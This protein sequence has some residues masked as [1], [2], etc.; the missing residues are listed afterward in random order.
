MLMKKFSDN[1]GQAMVESLI[2]LTLLAGLLLLLTDTVFPLHEHQLKRIETGR[3]AVWNWQLNSTVEVTENYAFAKRAEVVL[4]PLKGLTGLALEQDNL[5]VIASAPD[6]AAMARLT[7]TW[8][9]MSAEQLDSRPAR[10]TPLARLQELGLGKI[11]NFI[12]WLHFTEE[13]S[14]ESLRFGYIANEATPAEL[15]CQRGQS[16]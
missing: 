16:C 6:V 12:S 9:P 3:A 13:F 15:A 1:S 7:D 14:A 10:L 8:S 4:S 5:R 11:Q 2:V